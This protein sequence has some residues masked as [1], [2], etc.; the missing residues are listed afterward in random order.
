MF[1]FLVVVENLPIVCWKEHLRLCS[2]GMIQIRISD[3]WS[4][5]GS[6]ITAPRSF[7]S[8]C[9]KETEGSFSRVDS[10]VPLVHHDRSDLG[11]LILIRII[12]KESTLKVLYIQHCAQHCTQCH[13]SVVQC[14]AFPFSG[15]DIW[16]NFSM[17][18][19]LRT[20]LLEWANLWFSNFYFAK[21]RR[22][23]VHL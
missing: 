18:P 8:W 12:P 1:I 14:R 21:N 10:S 9:I 20:M 16:W 6:V 2:F 23:W 5:S 3:Y 19:L 4:R 13:G 17:L 15:V 7:G 11:S 22:Q